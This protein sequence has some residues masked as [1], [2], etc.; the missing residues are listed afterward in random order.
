MRWRRP[1]ADLFALLRT[2]A[3]YFQVAGFHSLVGLAAVC[4]SI[5]SYMAAGEKGALPRDARARFVL[6]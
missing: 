3:S 1:P 6:P 5:S 4:A 2:R